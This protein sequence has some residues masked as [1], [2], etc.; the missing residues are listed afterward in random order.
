MSKIEKL[1][2]KLLS[3]PKDMEWSELIKILNYLGFTIMQQGV[4]G[5]QDV[6]LRI[7]TA[8]KYIFTN[9]IRQKSLKSMQLNRLL[10][11]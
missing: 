7:K 1:I 9:R 5:V 3:V 4:T 6:A 8:L 11:Y 2:Q 10:I